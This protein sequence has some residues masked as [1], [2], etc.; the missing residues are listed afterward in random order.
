MNPAKL[1]YF[2]TWY[3]EIDAQ[4]CSIGSSQSMT[5]GSAI[6]YYNDAW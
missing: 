2:E 4:K 5:P 3:K 1:L 6:L